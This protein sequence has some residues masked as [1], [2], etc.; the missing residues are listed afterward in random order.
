MS[1]EMC[2]IELK[3]GPK[4][5]SSEHNRV[6]RDVAIING[7]EKELAKDPGPC[8][9]DQIKRVILKMEKKLKAAGK[10]RTGYQTIK[11]SLKACGI[12]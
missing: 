9:P 1:W 6:M 12:N 10:K 4:V 3:P 2:V 11:N 8:G 5:K 7:Y